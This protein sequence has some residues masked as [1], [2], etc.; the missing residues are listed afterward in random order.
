M[1]IFVTV[2]TTN[3]D[4]L[5]KVADE[6]A[7]KLTQHSFTFQKADG[8]YKPLYGAYF[9]FV[10]DVNEYYQHAD[11]VITH[12]G[13]GSVYKLLEMHKKIIVVPNFDRV[14]KHQAD[15]ATFL[16]EHNYALVVWQ[17]TDLQHLIEKMDDYAPSI[18]RKTHF[19]K[20]EEIATYVMS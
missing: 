12:A 13:A 11:F 20:A 14:D 18:F 17:L 15:I 10:K 6:C 8:L 9:D 5:I 2:G 19:F 7:A 4:S 16:E 1:N 3:F